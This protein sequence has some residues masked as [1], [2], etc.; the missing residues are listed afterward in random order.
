MSTIKTNAILDASGGNTVTINSVTPTAYNTM[1]K[2]L[3]INGAMQFNQRGNSTGQTG[4]NYQMDRWQ[5]G[6]NLLG[7]WSSSQSTVAP[8]G[9]GNSWKMNCTTA[10][11]S[12]SA[13]AQF[14]LYTR[15]EGQTLQQIKKGTANAQ[16]LTLSFWCRCNKTGNFQTNLRDAD[17][18]R[19]VGAVVTINS[20]DTWEY[21]TIT[22][23]A[24]TTGVLDNDNAWSLSVEFWLDGGSDFTSGSVPT[25]WEAAVNTDRAAGTTLALGD[26]TSN[27]FYITGVQ[28]EV[29]SVATE[30]ERRPYGTE[31]A[32]CQRYYQTIS[33]AMG[34]GN[35]YSSAQIQAVI[36]HLCT[37]R[38]A[39]SIGYTGALN[40]T[41]SQSNFTQSSGNV[42]S[43]QA[44]TEGSMVV[45]GNFS[46]VTGFRPYYFTSPNSSNRLITLSAEL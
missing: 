43:T 45:F 28:L 15:L 35:Y 20:A 33:A 19:Q 13:S 1:G 44:A 22:F 2:N 5:H 32:L 29:G 30:F 42:S 9:F 16:Q 7:T 36:P 24:D 38:S 41:D 21:K 40:F 14:Y 6:I 17:N 8:D 27:E 10:N 4:L 23:P 12:P 39:P 34:V 37:M 31:L 26:S 18:T 46:G 3:I 11:A 25:A